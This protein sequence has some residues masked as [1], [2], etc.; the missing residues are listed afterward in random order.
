MKNKKYDFAGYVTKND[1]KCIDGLTIRHGAFSHQDKAKVPLVWQHDHNS[2]ENVLGH[3]ILENRED[4]VYGYGYLNE[5]GMGAKAKELI[6]HGDIN[7]LSIWA[8]GLKKRA[9]DVLHGVIREVSLVLAGANPGAMIDFVD[10]AHGE[11]GEPTEAVIWTDQLIHSSDLAEEILNDL[12]DE[13]EEEENDEEF[14]MESDE[15]DIKHSAPTVGEVL[16]TLSETQRNA[17]ATLLDS[18]IEE[19]SK[20]EHT[21]IEEETDLKKN[22]F[23]HMSDDETQTL[24]HSGMGAAPGTIAHTAMLEGLRHSVF[25][26]MYDEEMSLQES[27]EANSEELIKHGIINMEMLFPDAKYVGDK[28]YVY[29]QMNTATDQIL[30][31]VRKVPFA[32]LKNLIADFTAD[33]ARA[34]GYIKGDEKVDQ[35]FELYGRE[36]YPQTIYKKQSYDRDDVIDITEIDLINF[37]KTE[38]RM[39]LNQELAR[40]I[41]V[42]DGRETTDAAKIKAD[43]IRPIISDDDFY[44]IKKTSTGVGSLLEDIIKSLAEYRG[45]GTPDLWIQ[46]ELLVEFKLIKAND[47]RYLF[48]DIPT[49]ASMAARLGVNSII[50]TTF[51]GTT[52]GALIVNLSDY[53]LG[54][55]K[56]GE[57]TTFDDFDIDFN[58]LKY[59][60]ETRCSGALM[61]PKSAIYFTVGTE[62]TNP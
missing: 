4:G 55:N 5:S 51:F 22:L 41:I 49:D 60:I 58:K 47:G 31:K 8:N 26:T 11:E 21:S 16:G 37:T 6:K 3:M 34:R 27:L 24:M 62:T 52:R 10:L 25:Q 23:G 40:A 32:R 30:A 54:A 38:M 15:E 48:G 59:L 1:I 46:P 28:P 9:Q 12:D 7:S 14:K 19:N 50:P 61:V 33:E 39:M 29:A 42:G 36:T 18:L 20:L 13:D 43:K 2:P 44:T 35:V 57:V 17:V 45:S 53:N 56:G